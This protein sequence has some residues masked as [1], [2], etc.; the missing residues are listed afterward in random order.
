M[1]YTACMLKTDK[2]DL[3]QPVTLG[4]FQEFVDGFGEVVTDIVQKANQ[5]TAGIIQRDNQNMLEEIRASNGKVFSANE[6]LMMSNDR[7][8]G[9]IKAMREE[10]AA[11]RINHHDI[12]NDVLDL[13]KRTS[14]LEAHAGIS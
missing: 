6:N 10:D 7:I 1:W 14:R 12:T 3:D 5:K 2:K 8:A 13:K 9:D 4:D 11:H